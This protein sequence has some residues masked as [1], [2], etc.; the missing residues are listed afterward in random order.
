MPARRPSPTR[1]R[2][3]FVATLAERGQATAVHTDGTAVTYA[4]L[5]DRVASA[6]AA[7]GSGRRL[8]LVAAENSLDA[9]VT[10]LGALHAGHVPLLAPGDRLQHLV[11]LIGEYDPDVV[12]GRGDIGWLVSA[13]H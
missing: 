12:E 10:Y 4:A 9:L 5:A 13:R 1:Q 2:V 11:G 7:L 3:A 8:V 6:G